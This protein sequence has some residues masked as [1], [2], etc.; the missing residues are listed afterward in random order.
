MVRFWPLNGKILQRTIIMSRMS[1]MAGSRCRRFQIAASIY[2][3]SLPPILLTDY[4]FHRFRAPQSHVF[5]PSLERQMGTV[6]EVGTRTGSSC[7]SPS[8]LCFTYVPSFFP[9]RWQ[10]VKT[11]NSIGSQQ[12]PLGLG[13][14]GNT[15]N[16]TCC[17]QQQEVAAECPLQICMFEERM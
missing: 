10:N 12:V 13:S 16:P 4:C 3:D 7:L 17:L 15:R 6:S 2:A 9:H 5:V 1:E 8:S 11:M 14:Q